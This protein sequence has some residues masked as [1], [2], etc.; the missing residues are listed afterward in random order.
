M[1]RREE[2]REEDVDQVV[3]RCRGGA[4]V[5]LCN[6][7]S[8]RSTSLDCPLTNRKYVLLNW[9]LETQKSVSVIGSSFVGKKREF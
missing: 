7:M 4:L 1:R 2:Q 9:W 3:R 5:T 6:R 8:Q